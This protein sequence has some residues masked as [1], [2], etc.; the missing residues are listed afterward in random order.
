V[1]ERSLTEQVEHW[2]RLGEAVEAVVTHPTVELLKTL[3]HDERLPERLAAADTPAGRRR[4]ARLVRLRG[5]PKYGIAPDDPAGV[6]R[7]ETDGAR[8]RGRIQGGRFVA[9]APRK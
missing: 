8:T 4:V 3:S 7:H 5:G 9:N 1:Q 6:V 2:A